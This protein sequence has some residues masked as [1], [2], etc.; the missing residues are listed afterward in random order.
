MFPSRLIARTSLCALL[1]WAHLEANSAF[2]QTYPIKPIRIVTSSAG[3]GTD[4]LS[5]VLAN[6]ISGSLGQQIIVD[7]RSTALTGIVVAQAP[8]DGYTLSLN[9]TSFWLA[10]LL[11]T[12]PTYNATD[13]A[14][15]TL[16][17]TS[18]SLIVVH[19]SLPTRS[20]K[21]LIALAK[22][23][24]GELNY[25]SSTLGAPTHLAA[26]LFKSMANVNIARVSY[27]GNGPAL[28]SLI[29]GEVQLMFTAAGSATAHIDSGRLRA[30]AVAS[31]KPTALAPGL[32]TVAEI[33]P[34]YVV[35]STYG[36]LAPAKTPTAIIQ[37]LNQEVLRFINTPSVKEQ[38]FKTGIEVVGST[39]EQFA[40]TIETDLRVWGKLIKAIGVKTD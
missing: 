22:A 11:Q 40:A 25:G 21:E 37:R 4:F 27:K 1:M 17:T 14:P 19:A 34:G 28:L 31:A 7:N 12:K 38:L 32:P 13:F 30:L 8:P 10:P 15:I 9:G 39:P 24:P 36:L 29:S 6:G 35:A 33:V 26:E 3:G 23:R 2:G 16:M 20:V 5:R 18:P